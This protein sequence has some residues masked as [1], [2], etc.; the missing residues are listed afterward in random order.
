[1]TASQ[2]SCLNDMLSVLFMCFLLSDWLISI[3][4]IYC[5]HNCGPSVVWTRVQSHK[6]HCDLPHRYHYLIINS[7]GGKKRKNKFNL[8]FRQLKIW[9]LNL[10]YFISKMCKPNWAKWKEYFTI[11]ILISSISQTPGLRSPK[12][13]VSFFKY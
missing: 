8:G 2:K 1:M 3:L 10:F 9:M 4:Y 13:K 5:L 7:F 11:Y 12:R 6:A